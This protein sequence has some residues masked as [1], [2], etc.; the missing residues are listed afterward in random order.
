MLNLNG[1]ILAKMDT[2]EAGLNVYV[3]RHYPCTKNI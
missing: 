2:S 1:A 3:D